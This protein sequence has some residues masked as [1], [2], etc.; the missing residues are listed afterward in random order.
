MV[1]R[2][3][4]LFFSSPFTLH[5]IFALRPGGLVIA[6]QLRPALYATFPQPST[7]GPALVKAAYATTGIFF[8]PYSILNPRFSVR[9]LIN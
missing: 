4:C 5:F 7:L 8:S 2:Y 9:L 1:F 6:T 3:L